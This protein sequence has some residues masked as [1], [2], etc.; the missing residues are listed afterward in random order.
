MSAARNP[1]LELCQII[2]RNEHAQQRAA[3]Y[4]NAGFM[5]CGVLKVI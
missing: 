5:V 3:L 4:G 2:V 1:C